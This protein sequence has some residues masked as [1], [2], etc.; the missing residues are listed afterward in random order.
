[1]AGLAADSPLFF[2]G[3]AL[4]CLV[5]ELAAMVFNHLRAPRCHHL[6]VA[7]SRSLTLANIVTAISSHIDLI[8]AY[9]GVLRP[10]RGPVILS[11]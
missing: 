2:I 1:M 7:D 3:Q 10:P 9:L 4:F 6:A 5:D 8:V 11:V